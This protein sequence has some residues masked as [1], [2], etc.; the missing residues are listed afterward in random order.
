MLFNKNLLSEP[1]KYPK[2]GWIK[3]KN[4]ISNKDVT[5][6]KKIIKNNFFFSSKVNKLK[7]LNIFFIVN[8]KIK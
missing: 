2:I 5:I 7:I 8:N 6:T 1:V 4:K 3:V